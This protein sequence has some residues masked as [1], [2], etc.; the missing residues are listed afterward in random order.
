MTGG[1][2]DI[3][4]DAEATNEY[5]FRQRLAFT[6]EQW[7]SRSIYLSERGSQDGPRKWNGGR[8]GHVVLII[9]RSAIHWLAGFGDRILGGSGA[10]SS[11]GAKE[12][13]GLSG[14][15]VDGPNLKTEPLW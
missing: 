9:D 13:H 1:S 3:P 14:E 15:N 2:E 5:S 10:A 6:F 7:R 12:Q 4:S 11:A 8:G